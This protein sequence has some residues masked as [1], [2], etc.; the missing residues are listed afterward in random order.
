MSEPIVRSNHGE[1]PQL[2][3][4]RPS[5]VAVEVPN[6]EAIGKERSVSPLGNSAQAEQLESRSETPV[7]HLSA[8]ECYN[9]II[10]QYMETLYLSKTPLAYFAK[11]PLSRVRAAFS[12]DKNSSP[13]IGELV[14]FVRSL[15]LNPAVL[16]K[17][18]LRKLPGIIKNTSAVPAD[19]L[20]QSHVEEEPPKKRKSTKLKPGKDGLF[21]GE[22]E[23]VSKWWF[24]HDADVDAAAGDDM[25]QEDLERKKSSL[26]L[27]ETLMQIILSLEAMALEKSHTAVEV[28]TIATQG[29]NEIDRERNKLEGRQPEPKWWQEL[30]TCVDV[31][32]DK[33]CI[34][35][36][37]EEDVR[38]VKQ[39]KPERVD[40]RVDH[41]LTDENISSK[42]K[43]FC[44][45]IIVPL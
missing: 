45:E 23:Y 43:S 21:P 38:T 35:Q 44:V 4:Q 19:G 22:D 14:A 26:R 34:W 13:Q 41:R 5:S 18:H 30:K 31:L 29:T 1:R 7:P 9:F 20:G 11:G 15:L 12:A 16:D 28:A 10:T 3:M 37:V 6:S 33:L 17:K 27:R 32:V 39:S 36:S 40:G 42:L 24:A 8:Q 2:S 25:P